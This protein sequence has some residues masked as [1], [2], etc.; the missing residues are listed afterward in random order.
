MAIGSRGGGSGG[1]R[2]GGGGGDRGGRSGGDRGGGGW[3]DP[4]KRKCY[5]CGVIGHISRH[6]PTKTGKDGNKVIVDSFCSLNVKWENQMVKLE[7]VAVV[8]SCPFA[9][10]LG[11]DWIVKSKTN[12]IVED[13]KI[14]AKLK[15]PSKPKVKKVRFAGIDDEI[16]SGEVCYECP[17]IVKGE[18][19]EALEKDGTKRR[20]STCGMEVKVVEST[21]IPAESLCFIKAKMSK[22]FSGNVVVRP[23]MCSHPGLEWIIPSCIVKVTAGKLKIP[24]L[25][26]K[27]SVLNLRRK[28]LLAFVDPDFDPSVVIVGQ[29]EQP[30]NPACPLISDS[31]QPS[32][33]VLEDA[34]I[35]ENLST[36]ERSAVLALL[37]RRLRCFPTADGNLGHTNMAEHAIDTESAHPI[38]CVPYRVSAPE[39]RIIMEKIAEMLRQGIIHRNELFYPQWKFMEKNTFQADAPEIIDEASHHQ[40]TSGTLVEISNQLNDEIRNV[41]CESLKT[42]QFLAM[43]TAQSSPMLAGIILGLLTCQRVQA[44]GQT[45]IIQQC[46]KTTVKVEA[47]KTKCGFEPKFNGYTIGKDGFTRTKFRPC[48]WSNGLV[49]LNGKTFEYVNE[50]WTPIKPNIKISSIG[51]KSHF[52]EEVDIEAKYLHNLETS[53]HSKENEQMNMIGELMAVMQHDTINPISPILTHFDEKTRFDLLQTVRLLT[54]SMNEYVCALRACVVVAE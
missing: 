45:M 11:A 15:E 14:I 20:N 21:V 43:T 17:L 24:V 44:D 18:L 6:C 48:T 53:F 7:N 54:P 19:I 30:V 22:N 2:G 25:N 10:I 37:T 29:E 50:T 5:N 36:E 4:S 42:K 9:L 8:K 1:D 52:E 35:G 40:Y 12:L 46:K 26:M 38:S 49:N 33:N 28:D 16:V 47:H 32:W 23:N 39:R 31:E 13:D 27:E 3:V 41:Y 34:R 51:L